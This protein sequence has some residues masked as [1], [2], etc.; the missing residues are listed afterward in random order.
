MSVE[1]TKSEGLTK[2]FTIKISAQDVQHKY[3]Q[4]I[5][6]ISKTGK[7]DGF[8]PAK[9]PLSMV[10]SKYGKSVYSEIAGKMIEDSIRKLCEDRKINLASTPK[11]DVKEHALGKDIVLSLEVESTPE[12]V[13]PDFKKITL[14]CPLVDVQEKDIDDHLKD[15]AEQ[16]KEYTE[17]KDKVTSGDQVIIDF[18]GKLDGQEFSGGKA[19][20]QRLE[21]GSKTMIPGFEEQILGHK[22]GDK[23]TIKV[24]FPEDYTS[25]E[26]E[27][28]DAEFDIVLHKVN[29]VQKSKIDNQLAKKLGA[30]DLKDLI[31]KAREMITANY[32]D[33]AH[34]MLKMQL[35]DELETILTF[36]VPKSMY[37]KE[38]K[39][40]K[41]Q[42]E[43]DKSMTESLQKKSTQD[44]EE[45]YTKVTNRRVR[46]GLMLSEFADKHNLKVD[47]QDIYAEVT[48][49]AR[50]MPGYEQALLDFYQKNPKAVEALTGAVLENKA[51]AY[52]L[53]KEITRTETTLTQEQFDQLIE[54]ENNKVLI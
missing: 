24:T 44:T 21:I 22:T 3:D 12:I 18:N 28:K 19:E 39:A 16:H 49:R 47:K 53:E 36:D 46:I 15:I 9:I 34:V 32:Q 50:S 2:H 4:E 7:F 8:R 10:E 31:E 41:E 1:K 20:S 54:K 13:F 38:Y 51:V 27:G 37:D 42:T 23:F 35:F 14:E 33:Q 25:K 40:V 17:K 48:R 52:I 43:Q 11:V 45:Y 29:T 5:V 26:L 6:K 30:K